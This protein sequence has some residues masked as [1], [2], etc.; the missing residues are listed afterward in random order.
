MSTLPRLS[1]QFH[2]LS[3]TRVLFATVAWYVV[4]TGLYYLDEQYDL[5]GEAEQ[6]LAVVRLPAPVKRFVS[7]Y[8]PEIVVYGFGA[9]VASAV[10]VVAIEGVRVGWK[11]LAVGLACWVTVALS[12]LMTF[13][14]DHRA[15]LF[16]LVGWDGRLPRRD[17]YLVETL[18]AIPTAALGTLVYCLFRPGAWRE[19]SSSG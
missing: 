1:R 14:G 12:V 10:G 3:W 9:L 13:D 7:R 15:I 16:H 6:Q 11:R 5:C 2:G 18:L 8:A 17:Y 4:F 19:A